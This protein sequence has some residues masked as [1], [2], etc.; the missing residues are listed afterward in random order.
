[1]CS[2]DLAE[3]AGPVAATEE[4]L[5]APAGERSGP[6]VEAAPPGAAR[7]RPA[8]ANETQRG[9]ARSA[10]APKEAE[11]QQAMM[12]IWRMQRALN[13]GRFD[14]VIALAGEHQRQFGGVLAREREALRRLAEGR[15]GS[16]RARDGARR[17]TEQ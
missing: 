7:E 3:E 9:P 17:A 10:S 1:M 8:S 16:E 15:L 4:A 6:A 5:G 2:S 11:E 12:L 14:G 13:A